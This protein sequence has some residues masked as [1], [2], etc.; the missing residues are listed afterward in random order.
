MKNYREHLILTGT[1]IRSALATF[2]KLAENAIAF[3]VDSNDR[4]IGS[5]TDGDVRRALIKGTN[6]DESVDEIIQKNPKFI[7]KSHFKIDTLISFR[8]NFFRIIPVLDDQNRIIDIINFGKIKSYL[9]VDAVIMAGGKGMRL[10]PLTENTPKP[11]LKVGDKPIMEHNID[12]LRLFGIE[13]FWISINYLGDQIEDYFKNGADKNINIRY[14]KENQPLGTIGSVT[15]IEDLEHEYILLTNSDL[16]TNIDYE[17]FFLQALKKN[18]DMAIA[19]IPYSVEIP[20]AVFETE[21]GKILNF[22]EKPTYTYYSNAGI[23]LIKKECLKLIPKDQFYNATD[24]MNNLI[25]QG[26][27][28]FSYHLIG[29]WL[30]IGKHEDFKKAQED[31]KQVNI[32]K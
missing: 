6:I 26:K 15:G 19:T 21:N 11:L 23:Y 4:L 9:P 20:Y 12:R 28:V 24:L 5:L 27:F 1:T 30:D 22:K 14:V 7:Y 17:D 32:L 18:A 2:N 16:L 25:K 8:E 3:V 29:Y 31:I 13:N 10:R